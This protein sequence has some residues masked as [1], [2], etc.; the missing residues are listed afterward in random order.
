MPIL[1]I[2]SPANFSAV[3]TCVTS[4]KVDDGVLVVWGDD[5]TGCACLMKSNMDD[6]GVVLD[7]KCMGSKPSGE[8]GDGIYIEAKERFTMS[9]AWTPENRYDRPC[10]I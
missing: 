6:V 2:A 5:G 4:V 9:T 7:V 8:I 3:A 10:W 1:K